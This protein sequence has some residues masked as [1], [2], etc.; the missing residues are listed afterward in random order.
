ME[1]WRSELYQTLSHSI[2]GS[3]WKDHKYIA[4]VNG[5][6]IYPE[7]VDKD[8]GY[9]NTTG[10][11]NR[12]SKISKSSKTSTKSYSSGSSSESSSNK[13]STAV[14]PESITYTDRGSVKSYK[15]LPEDP[16]IGDV[17][18]LE[19]TKQKVY[20]DGEIWTPYSEQKKTKKKS[21]GYVVGSGEKT[22]NLTSL[23]PETISRI[24]NIISGSSKK[25]NVS[26]FGGG[27]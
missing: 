8:K 2:E 22:S 19:D 24:R 11:I 4:I 20:W 26:G 17:Y 5:K 25:S 23:K 9:Y 12:V 13:Q 3:T 1:S 18:L 27:R 10:H 14:N 16:A 15:F 7:D 6:Y 21:S